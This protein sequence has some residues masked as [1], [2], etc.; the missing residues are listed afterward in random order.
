MMPEDYQYI[1]ITKL[2]IYTYVY[3]YIYLIICIYHNTQ[4]LFH[5]LNHTANE[6]LSCLFLQ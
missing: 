3:K 4:V 5:S 2:Y 6:T 1:K